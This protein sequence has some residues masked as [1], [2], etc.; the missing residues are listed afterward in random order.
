MSIQ[1][2]HIY[3]LFINY[4]GEVHI[5]K[6][7][8]KQVHDISSQMMNLDKQTEGEAGVRVGRVGETS[9][10]VLQSQAEMWPGKGS[11][12]QSWQWKLR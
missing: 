6:N 11:K 8:N 5:K 10:A 12:P 3:R 1:K 2:T 7:K 9:V 4:K